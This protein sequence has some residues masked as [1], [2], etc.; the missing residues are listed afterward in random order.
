M[1]GTVLRLGVALICLMGIVLGGSLAPVIGIETSVSD[2]GVE[3]S[4]GPANEELLVDSDSSG[5]SGGSSVSG[6]NNLGAGSGGNGESSEGNGSEV[7]GESGARAGGNG[8]SG[9][10]G[11]SGEETASGQDS[12]SSGGT[13]ELAE[14]GS[15]AE[16]GVENYGGVS[17][18][19]YPEQNTVGGPLSLSDHEELR[20]E[21]PEPSRWRLGAYATY[22]GT[23]WD[24][25]PGEQR[26]LDGPLHVT[27]GNPEPSHEIR[28]TVN[29][30]FDALA[31]A[32]RPLSAEAPNTQVFVTEERG[33]TV[34]DPIEAGDTYTTSTYGPP[35]HEAAASTTGSGTIPPDIHT[36]Y[37]QLPE[38]TPERL[39]DRTAGITSDA[40]T[41]YETAAAVQMWLMENKEYSLDATHDREADVATAFVFDM[42][43][44]YC[45]YFATTMVAMLRTQDIPARYVTGYTAGEEVDDGEY[46]VRGQN[47]HAWV[48]VYIDDVGWVPFDPTPPSGRSEAGRDNA[49]SGYAGPTPDSLQS[50][51]GSGSSDTGQSNTGGNKETNGQD[52]SGDQANDSDE[53]DSQTDSE[54]EGTENESEEDSQT[55]PEEDTQTEEDNTDTETDQEGSQNETDDEEELE[56]LE[57]EPANDPVPGSDLTVTVT[58]SGDPVSGVEVLFNGE[59]VGETD[60]DGNVTG[61]VPYVA[62]L[63]IVARDDNPEGQ[64]ESLAS[65]TQPRAFEGIAGSPLGSKVRSQLVSTAPVGIAARGLG[66]PATSGDT[67]AQTDSNVT[68][69]VPVDIDIEPQTKPIAGEPVTLRATIDGAPVRNGTVRVNG[70]EVT[71]TGANGEARAELP[72]TNAAEVAVSRGEAF[73]NRTISVATFEM[74]TTASTILPLPLTAT[75]ITARVDG[76]PVEN[77]TVA[78]A[79]ESAAMT[80]PAGTAA[81]T[82]PLANTAT[83]ETTADVDGTS[84]TATTTVTNL[85]RNLALV[86]GIGVVGVGVVGRRVYRSGTSVRSAS[87]SVVQVAVGLVRSAVAGLVGIAA[88]FDHMVSALHRG[89]LRASA[90]L[91]EGVSGTI[92]LLRAL[93][94]HAAR[95]ARRGVAIVRTLPH[96]LHPLTLLAS[97]RQFVQSLRTSTRGGG[98]SASS[99]H[100]GH[101]GRPG[102]EPVDDELLTIRE[103]WAEFRDHVSIRSWRTSTPGE[104]A[105]WAIR[106]DELPPESVRT[107]T[108]AFRDVEYG[109]TSPDECAPAARDALEQIRTDDDDTEANS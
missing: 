46:V 107:L 79:G 29:R 14:D 6:S 45:Q 74:T 87:R 52:E 5:N 68:V 106:R 20:I 36:R 70:T 41:P 35:S 54:Q 22:T 99:A 13:T 90:L 25:Q 67:I 91:R 53:E 73:G 40:E 23:G 60:G 55:E 9:E 64:A 57:I 32:W 85:Y 42:E 21:S 12:G 27:E 86:L 80:G 10:R 7:S 31:T 98:S 105:R 108:D 48:E 69:N 18:G 77:A 37:T 103:A 104:I 93:S 39:G 59:S 47:A 92:Q 100:R 89:V 82:L 26:P 61:E 30:S 4:D 33:L 88:T 84:T 75:E 16:S 17:G 24:R 96:R 11:E 102:E 63:E 49:D 72:T 50:G 66:T 65:N 94:R 43:A 51:P 71:Q 34:S 76:E 101:A 83:I 81:V 62:S 28:V 15:P 78:V 2:L 19:G 58:R 97:L 95:A 38:E 3:E 56:P 8:E 1:K 109:N 44:G